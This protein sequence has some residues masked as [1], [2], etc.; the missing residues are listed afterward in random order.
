MQPSTEAGARLGDPVNAHSPKGS[1]SRVVGV[2]FAPVAVEYLI[3]TL[4][5]H[6]NTV[7]DDHRLAVSAIPEL[8]ERILQGHLAGR[9]RFG[10]PCGMGKTTAVRATLRAM[11]LLG[12]PYRIAVACSKVEELCAL[13]RTLIAEDGV[14]AGIIGLLHSYVHDV[15]RADSGSDGYASEASEGH[16]R[17]FLLVTHANVQ[18][19]RLRPWMSERDLVFFDESLIV[20]E[21]QTLNLMSDS[22]PCVVAEWGDL[23]ARAEF[24]PDLAPCVHWFDSL[25]RRLMAQVN[26]HQHADVRIV[27]LEA[28]DVA[29]TASFRRLRLFATDR[30]PNLARLLELTER[31]EELR[32]FTSAGSN[33]SLISYRTSVPEELRN[34]IVLDASDPIRELVHHDHRMLKAED[35]LESLERFRTVPGGLASIKHHARVRFHVAGDAGGR[36]A[37]RRAFADADREA[38][39]VVEKLVRLVKSKPDESFLIFTYRDRDGVKYGKTLIRALENAGINYPDINTNGTARLNILTWGRETATNAYAQCQNVVLLGV[40]FQPQES[41]AGRF[42]GQVDDLRSSQLTAE[43]NRL[44]YSECAHSIYQAVNRACMRQVEVVSGVAQAKPCNVYLWHRDSQ[45]E[46][47]LAPVLRGVP[48]WMPWRE[49]GEELSALDIARLI[50]AKLAQYEQQGGSSVS[51]RKLKS[52][53]APTCPNGTWQRARDLARE[54]RPQWTVRGRSLVLMFAA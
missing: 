4:E 37:M 38:P 50:A 3:D 51:S 48:Q 32:V 12:L 22:A 25:V 26:G 15:T 30:L 39:W 42:L 40:I 44:R 1:P 27:K 19:E 20:G 35:V 29:L 13:K 16:D 21:A 34:V 28:P 43:L 6:G 17:Q 45:I 46:E 52:A 8:A 49:Q 54:L 31:A 53:V 18:S 9:F 24:F 2:K 7:S 36:E 10:L 23:R 33:R 5:R 47:R 11:H 41:I 14:P